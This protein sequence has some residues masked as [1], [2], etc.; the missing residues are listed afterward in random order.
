MLHFNKSLFPKL[1]N[2][3]NDAT[4]QEHTSTILST[5]KLTKGHPATSMQT[6]VDLD[7][8][9]VIAFSFPLHAPD[10]QSVSSLSSKAKPVDNWDDKSE[11]AMLQMAEQ[12]RPW[13]YQHS[14][15]EVHYVAIVEML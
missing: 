3:T 4:S 1:S 9:D 2:I 7:I 13:I 8:G 10:M 15:I 5:L 14:K 12:L 6:P 11:F